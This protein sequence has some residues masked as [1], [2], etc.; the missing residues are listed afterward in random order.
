M[1]KRVITAL[2]IA[3]VVVPLILLGGIPFFI[4]VLALMGVCMYEVTNVNKSSLLTRIFSILFVI[5]ATLYSYFNINHRFMDFNLLFVFIPIITFFT[6][7][8]FSKKNTLLDA[9]Y[10]S[11]MTII[12][13]LFATSLLE[14]RY[15]LNNANLIAYLIITTASVDTFALLVGCKFG[16]HRLNERIS[17]KKSIEGAIGGVIF[18]TIIATLFATFFPILNVGDTNVLNLS[19]SSNVIFANVIYSLLITLLLTI[20]GQIGDLIFSMIKR[21]Y[22]IKDF[23]NVLPGHGG[24]A[25]RVDSL[26]INSVTL[27]L[28]LSIISIL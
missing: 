3:A 1:K 17:P 9:C 24:F 19:F 10:N 21:N 4:G 13:S 23:S 11:I 8:M 2:L 20:V 7:S 16:K 12:F 15:T 6:I 27:A 14:L 26:C 22:N 28:I 5:V 25:D 18:G